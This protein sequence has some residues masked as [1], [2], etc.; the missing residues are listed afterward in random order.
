MAPHPHERSRPGGTALVGRGRGDVVAVE[1]RWGRRRDD[2]GQHAARRGGTVPGPSADATGD[3]PAVGER[4]SPGLG[5]V[6]G[7][8]A[9]SRALAAG[10]LCAGTVAC[11]ASMGGRGL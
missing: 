4:V 5:G 3:P 9:A 7:G 8:A 1:C 10:P 2:S 11:G 6:D